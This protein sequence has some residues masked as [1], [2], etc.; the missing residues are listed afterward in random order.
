MNGSQVDVP[1]RRSPFVTLHVDVELLE[2]ADKL[3]INKS[4]LFRKALQLRVEHGEQA[5]LNMMELD[6]VRWRVQG[7][8]EEIRVYKTKIAELEDQLQM[9]LPR[10]EELEEQEKI[11]Q[12]AQM[13]SEMFLILRDICVDHDFDIDS[14]KVAAKEV[15]EKIKTAMPEFDLEKHVQRLKEL[16]L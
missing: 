1:R 14:I 8:K 5:L 6:E 3:N 4:Q 16:I 13:L 12:R 7:L 9:L 11:Y 15:I 10:L 2:K